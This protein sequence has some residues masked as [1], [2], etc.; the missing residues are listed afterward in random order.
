MDTCI[1]SAVA[2]QF[3][4]SR[5]YLRVYRIYVIIFFLFD[6][7]MCSFLESG[8]NDTELRVIALCDD[9]HSRRPRSTAVETLVY[10]LNGAASV[11]INISF[12]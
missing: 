10:T 7:C 6:G 4:S 9:C 5:V 3:R 2:R 1:T 11:D 12:S 8:I